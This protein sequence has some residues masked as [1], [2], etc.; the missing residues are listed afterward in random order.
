MAAAA[1]VATHAHQL[2]TVIG[3]DKNKM[4]VTFTI[5]WIFSSIFFNFRY[6]SA[7][8]HTINR[9]FY[10]GLRKVHRFNVNGMNFNKNQLIVAP[11]DSQRRSKSMHVGCWCNVICL[12][13]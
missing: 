6:Q 3:I 1:A 13:F 4:D 5:V 10:V 8:T 7:S 12:Q 11:V 2:D 9:W